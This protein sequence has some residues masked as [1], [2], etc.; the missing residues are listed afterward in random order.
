M[1]GQIPSLT[2]GGSGNG[3]NIEACQ[4]ICDLRFICRVGSDSVRDFKIRV[5]D[6]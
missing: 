4:R 5:K 3:E 2:C 1:T 6:R